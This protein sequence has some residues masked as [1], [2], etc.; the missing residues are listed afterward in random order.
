MV[1]RVALFAA[2]VSAACAGAP[3]RVFAASSLTDAFGEIGALHTARHSGTM[4]F[5]FGAT[6]ELRVQIEHGARADVFAAA[7]AE[8]MQRALAA[9]TVQGSPSTFARNALVV[10]A[11]RQASPAIARLEDLARPGLKL[12]TAHPNVPIGGYARTVLEKMS[13]DPAYGPG[14]RRSVTENIVS[15]EPNVRH[16]LAKVVLGEAD[17]GFVYRSDV[18]PKAAAA[19]LTLEIAAAHN[20][21]VVYPIAVAATTQQPDRAAQF[22]ATVLSLDGQAILKKHGFRPEER[23]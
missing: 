22:I 5:S 8:E 12:V 23:P 21:D 18:H 19:V 1:T 10:V 16:V 6:T 9:R 7:S 2:L 3:L 15:L 13:R 4:T 17:A 20:V 14:W 11:S